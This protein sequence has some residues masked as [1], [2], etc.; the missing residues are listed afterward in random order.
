MNIGSGVDI[1]IKELSELISKA[2]NYQGS[3]I[4][5][6]SKPDG[7]PKKQLDISQI[8]KLGW[9]PKI[10]LENGIQSTVDYYKESIEKG[11]FLRLC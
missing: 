10:S 3:I 11:S 6:E 7:H 8:T 1:S 5:D 2:T 9:V 4:W